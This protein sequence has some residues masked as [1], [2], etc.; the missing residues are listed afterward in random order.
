MQQGLPSTTFET[1][2]SDYIK[3]TP[4]ISELPLSSSVKSGAR[5][6]SPTLKTLSQTCRD[7]NLI[8]KL[9]SVLNF[10]LPLPREPLMEET[11]ARLEVLIFLKKKNRLSGGLGN[12]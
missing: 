4:C 12:T 1:T 5:R 2:R 8:F 11:R 3:C 7:E 10:R 6:P 9:L